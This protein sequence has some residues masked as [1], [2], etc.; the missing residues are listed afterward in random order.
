[1]QI[2]SEDKKWSFLSYIP[3]F[4]FPFFVIASVKSV[5]SDFVLFHVR[6]GLA[7]FVITF[8]VLLVSIISSTLGLMLWGINLL[9]HGIGVYGVYEEKKLKIPVVGDFALKIP[10]Y[11][12]YEKLTGKAPDEE[13]LGEKT[14]EDEENNANLDEHKTN[15]Q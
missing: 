4:N 8:F 1:M 10:K 9:L 12:L 15:N 11:L 5:D 7:L 13:V 3:L 2:S 14:L 6:Q